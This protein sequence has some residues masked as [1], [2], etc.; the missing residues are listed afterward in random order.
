[1]TN[2]EKWNNQILDVHT[3]DRATIAIT[4]ERKKILFC[5]ACCRNIQHLIRFP[6]MLE[7][8]NITESFIDGTTNKMIFLREKKRILQYFREQ[9]SF[10]TINSAENAVCCIATSPF[11]SVAACASWSQYPN[12]REKQIK[13]FLDICFQPED[14][15]VFS[16]EIIGLAQEVY[17]KQNNDVRLI[18]A[19]ALEDDNLIEQANHLRSGEH[20][21]GCWVID[22]I[23]LSKNLVGK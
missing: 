18:L 23:K 21:K 2:L 4:D 7:L 11:Q 15:I 1:M 8:L 12:E 6:M 9:S 10:P 22:Q 14:S 17:D 16:N 3:W 13:F 5:L 20:C 19:D